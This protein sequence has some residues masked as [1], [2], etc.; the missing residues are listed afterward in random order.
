VSVTPHNS[1]IEEYTKVFSLC[2][3]KRE[4]SYDDIKLLFYTFNTPCFVYIYI[5]RER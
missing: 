3:E 5:E 2:K 4:K 1:N